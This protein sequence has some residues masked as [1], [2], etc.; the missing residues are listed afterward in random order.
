MH[1]L[2]LMLCA[3][4]FAG[5]AGPVVA[6]QAAWHAPATTDVTS[7]SVIF[8]DADVTLHGTL[9]IPR[10]QHPVPAIVVYHGASEPLANTPYYRHLSEGL[11]QIG[12]AV[13][14]FDRRGTGASTGKPDVA[15]QTLSDDGVSGANEIRKL[16]Q[17]DPARVGYWGI[18]QGGWLATLAAS[19]DPR[20][21]F[22]VAVS[23]PLVTPEAQ[24]EFAISNQ[25]HVLGRSQADIDAMLDARYKLDGYFNGRNSR[26]TAVAALARIADRPW[27]DK[28]YLP[29]PDGIS[30][31]P[32]KSS[33]RSEMDIDSFAAV[34]QVKVPIFYILGGEDPWIPAAQTVA[35]LRELTPTHPLLQYAVIPRANHLMMEPVQE[36]MDDASPAQIA[37]NVPQSPAYFMLL[38]SW[39]EKTLAAPDAKM[40]H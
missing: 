16:P 7:Q 14:L 31:D 26:D 37:V 25:L 29:K 24:M 32:S 2:V 5:S 35:R 19:H 18:S 8:S 17:I 6:Q 3:A 11:P 38:A 22:A 36:K 27:F 23:A 28:M 34:A 4:L 30:K 20:A 9:F 40:S 12:I 10:S 13:L 1:K 21:A 15:F 39:L 33:W